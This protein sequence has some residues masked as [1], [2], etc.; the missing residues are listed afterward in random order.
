MTM[1]QRTIT[2]ESVGQTKQIGLTMWVGLIQSVK[3]LN[4]TNGQREVHLPDND[5]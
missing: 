4:R 5:P 2:F 1:I 3:G